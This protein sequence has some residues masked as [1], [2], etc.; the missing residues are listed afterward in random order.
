MENI[1]CKIFVDAISEYN[2]FFETV[3]NFLNGQK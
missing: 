2:I 3:K 1:Y